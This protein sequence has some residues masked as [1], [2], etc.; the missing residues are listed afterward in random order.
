MAIDIL[1]EELIDL[2]KARKLFPGHTPSPASIWRWALYGINGLK[3][4]TI[5][6]GARRFTTKQA[7]HRFI[8]GESTSSNCPPTPKK[9]AGRPP[10]DRAA[11]ADELTKAGI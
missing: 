8:A 6:I 9:K 7:I 4:E 1:S 11:V 5:K 10:R 3:L 2:S